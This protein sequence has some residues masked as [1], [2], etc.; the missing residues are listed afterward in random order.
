MP[1][2][3]LLLLNLLEVL[4]H[5]FVNNVFLPVDQMNVVKELKIKVK[6]IIIVSN[7]SN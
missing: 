2:Y 5:V 6:S 1:F 4:D 7:L 3:E